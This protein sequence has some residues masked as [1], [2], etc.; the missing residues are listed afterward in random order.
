MDWQTIFG[1]VSEALLI[2]AIVY[3]IVKVKRMED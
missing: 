1:I 3:L 2:G